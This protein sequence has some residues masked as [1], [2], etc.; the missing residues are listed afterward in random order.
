M[1]QCAEGYR[2]LSPRCIACDVG[3]FKVDELGC[4]KCPDEVDTSS[5]LVPLALLVA[6]ITGVGLLTCL[7]VLVATHRGGG[8]L[9]S[10]FKRT[11]QFVRWL[12]TILQMLA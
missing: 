9:R 7:I 12:I 2:D 6:G 1:A 10:S 5:I 3:Y 4:T 8:T 11:L